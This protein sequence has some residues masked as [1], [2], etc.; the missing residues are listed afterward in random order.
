MVLLRNSDAD[1]DR[2]FRL[3]MQNEPD[4][5]AHRL[6]YAD[7][8]EEHNRDD[9]A[10]HHRMLGLAMPHSIAARRFAEEETQGHTHVPFETNIHGSSYTAQQ[11]HHPMEFHH[12]FKGEQLK[13][14]GG[15][16]TASQVAQYSGDRAA[17][18]IN[19][20]GYTPIGWTRDRERE[21]VRR[22]WGSR[23]K[24]SGLN[25]AFASPQAMRDHE[26]A[27]EGYLRMASSIRD[28]SRGESLHHAGLLRRAALANIIAAHV[29]RMSLQRS[30]GLPS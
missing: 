22:T 21:A 6:I 3:S 10:L 24:H 16:R 8:L 28:P 15:P 1:M 12:F 26:Q 30:G 11:P 2:V 14:Q 5:P 27:A 29:H 18:A 19:V 23:T 4:E 13:S 20:Y 7:W 17:Q 25:M 9:E